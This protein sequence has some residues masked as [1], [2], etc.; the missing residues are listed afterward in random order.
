METKNIEKGV[1]VLVVAIILM[2]I[3]ISSLMRLFGITF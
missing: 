3:G 2:A 1:I